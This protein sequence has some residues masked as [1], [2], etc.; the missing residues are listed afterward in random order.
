M[1]ER[2][3]GVYCY[4]RTAHRHVRQTEQRQLE[5]TTDID[6]KMHYAH[7]DSD[8]LCGIVWDLH[9][10]CATGGRS[11]NGCSRCQSLCAVV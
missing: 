9:K 3:G 6:P 10:R 1:A 2:Q 7:T 4:V 8:A 11:E 5:R